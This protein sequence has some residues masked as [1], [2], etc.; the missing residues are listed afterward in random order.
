MTSR[1]AAERAHAEERAENEETPQEGKRHRDERAPKCA[2][3]QGDDTAIAVLPEEEGAVV[4][5]ETSKDAGPIKLRKLVE[6]ATKGTPM[7][8]CLSCL[9]LIFVTT[10]AM[11]ENTAQG[12]Y[13]C[14]RR[15][16]LL[17]N[18]APRP[19]PVN[20]QSQPR[21]KI[22]PNSANGENEKAGEFGRVNETA[23]CLKFIGRRV[24]KWPTW[25]FRLTT[26][27]EP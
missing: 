18:T 17:P 4:L 12:K 3:K 15:C 7:S 5:N 26:W 22:L 23:E 14:G 25:D 13:L 11:K 6:A 16:K 20:N 10:R 1:A 19:S 8:A 27:N 24:T 2:R 21:R 9:A